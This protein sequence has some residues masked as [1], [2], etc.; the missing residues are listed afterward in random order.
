MVFHMANSGVGFDRIAYAL[1]ITMDRLYEHFWNELLDARRVA[2]KKPLL[3]TEEKRSY[4]R[5]CAAAGI[6]ME[7]VA[8]SL[9]VD[10]LAFR[11]HFARDWESAPV[12]IVARVAQALIKNALNGDG[13]SQRFILERRG[14]GA[15]A[16]QVRH[17]HELAFVDETADAA[18]DL[19]QVSD[20]DLESMRNFVARQLEPKKPLLTVEDGEHQVGGSPSEGA[21]SDQVDVRPAAEVDEGDRE[22][23]VP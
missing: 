7:Q 10:Y 9:Q 12:D 14:F 5:L 17:E 8:S 20:A 3:F 23:A 21:R 19:G 22:G 11:K 13:P 6:P 15:W 16:E 1:G 4:V 18:F 2:G